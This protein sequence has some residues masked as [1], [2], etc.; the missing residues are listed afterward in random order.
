[1]AKKSPKNQQPKKMDREKRKARTYQII[2][3]A[4]TMILLLSMV[5]SLVSNK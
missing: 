2:F 4:L 3:F 1:M 5:L